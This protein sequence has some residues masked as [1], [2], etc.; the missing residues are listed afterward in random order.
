MR[1]ATLDDVPATVAMVNAHARYLI[2]ADEYT[3][4]SFELDEA[5]L[6]P[7]WPVRLTLRT[8]VPGQ[9]EEAVLRVLHEAFR[10]DWGYLAPSF[11][12]DLKM[13]RHWMT[14]PIFDPA[15]WLLV[16]DGERLRRRGKP[17]RPHLGCLPCVFLTLVC[18]DKRNI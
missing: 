14:D 16:M 4:E 7:A 3:V 2:G 17:A 8:F 9:D 12:E 11:D 10:D 1:S 13:L 15:L 5:P 6:L 18:Y